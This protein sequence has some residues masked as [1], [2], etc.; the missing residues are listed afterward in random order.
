MIQKSAVKAVVDVHQDGHL[1]LVLPAGTEITESMALEAS[2]EIC[3]L[4][5]DRKAALLLVLTGVNSLTR[6]AREIFGASRSLA[7]VAVLG[8]TPVD[9]V[10]ANFL[11]GGEVQ[12]CPTRYFSDEEDAV[13]WLGRHM[14]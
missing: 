5:Q 4:V 14:A 6:G 12:P 10:I 2:D 9:R 8:S 3:R 11:I 1:V 13:A 7:A